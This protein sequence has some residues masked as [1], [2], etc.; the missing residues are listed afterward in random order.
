MLGGSVPGWIHDGHLLLMY[1]LAWVPWAVGLAVVSVRSGRVIPD[2]RL[3]AVLVLQF[4]TGYLQGS[5]YLAATL[6][7]YYLF[8]VAWPPEDAAAPMR[9]WTPIAQLGV[10]AMLT[11]CAAAF[12]L[13][14]TSALVA[15]AGRSAGL[16]YR[17]AVE[18]SWNIRD[19]ASL[20]FPF[21]G[22]VDGPPHRSLSDHLAYVGWILTAFAPSRSSTV[23]S[24]HLDFLGL[25]S[26]RVCEL[27]DDAGGLFRLHYELLPGL[28]V[29]GRVL[30]LM[31]ISLALLGGIGLEAFLALAVE[32]RWRLAIPMLLSCAGMA[33]RSRCCPDPSPGNADGT[34]MATDADGTGGGHS[35]RHVGRDV[36][37]A[38]SGAGRGAHGGCLRR[39]IAD[40]P[41]TGNGP[42]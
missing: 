13:L 29:P 41:R 3:V 27:G 20:L 34:G 38:S 31:T 30:F 15:E 16:S 32:R 28:R 23:T 11:A 12:L 6:A 18:G 2:G 14:P 22:V 4:L 17:E 21:Y 26:R 42:D 35:D 25:W 36:E 37:M 5:V 19:L 10:L 9:R 7:F 1:S 24:A 39:H 8:S 33:A 40:D